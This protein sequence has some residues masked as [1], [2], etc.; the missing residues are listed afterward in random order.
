MLN[1]GTY[2]ELN[3]S[4]KTREGILLSDGDQ[5]VLLPY[6]DV[7]SDADPEDSYFVFVYADKEGRLLATTKRPLACAGDFAFL[8]AVGTTDQGAFL[9]LG[10]DKD[11]FVPS[12]EQ[13]KHMEK[14]HSYVVHV[15]TDKRDGRLLASSWLDEYVE[16]GIPDVE[17]GDEVSL[18]IAERSELGYS[19]VINNKYLGLLYHNE[20]YEELEIGETRQGYIKKIR[21]NNKIDLSLRPI[22]FDFILESREPLLDYIRRNG[23][24]LNLGDKSDPEEIRQRLQMSKKAFKQIIGGLYKQRMIT[25]S[26]HEVRLTDEGKAAGTAE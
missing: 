23:G 11:V 1:I 26:D 5:E 6:T 9:D 25:I 13:K 2:N 24:V 16:E 18:L 10:I 20:L 14:G 12:R 17:E 19:A 21:E 22:G 15:F 4:K 7:E 3:T 8:K